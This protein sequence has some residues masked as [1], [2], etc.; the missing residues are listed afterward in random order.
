MKRDM[1]IKIVL[2]AILTFAT[3]MGLN[4]LGS[5]VYRADHGVTHVSSVSH[6]Q[7]ELT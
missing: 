7:T 6:Q 2:A 3:L 1:K 4:A 5:A